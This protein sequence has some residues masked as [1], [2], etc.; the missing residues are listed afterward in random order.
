MPAT[1]QAVWR[2]AQKARVPMAADER[3]GV[4]SRE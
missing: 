4:V 3:V 1:P 2:A